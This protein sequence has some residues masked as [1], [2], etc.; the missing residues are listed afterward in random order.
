MSQVELPVLVTPGVS[1]NAI[2]DTYDPPLQRFQHLGGIVLV[3][4]FCRPLHKIV[5]A[6]L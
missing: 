3:V 6:I 5:G 2:I 4:H 1:Q